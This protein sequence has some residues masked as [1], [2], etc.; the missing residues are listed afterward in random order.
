MKV[1]KMYTYLGEN[2]TIVSPVLLNIY[3]I[4]KYQLI[5]DE[6][7]VLTKDGINTQSAVLVTEEDKDLWYEIDGGQ[8]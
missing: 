6:S 3:H 1:I 2:G 5:A 8:E 4:T 7:K